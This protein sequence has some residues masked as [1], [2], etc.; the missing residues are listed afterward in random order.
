MNLELF[1]V[2]HIERF[3]AEGKVS[4]A[5]Y[6]KYLDSLE[7]CAEEAE[8]CSVRFIASDPTRRPVAGEANGPDDE[9]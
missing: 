2:R 4:Q 5:D 3:L 7:D 8:V 9:G 6:Q 1:D